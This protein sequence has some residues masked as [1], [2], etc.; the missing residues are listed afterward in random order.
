MSGLD[1]GL[2]VLAVAGAFLGMKIGAVCALFNVAAGLAG[3]WAAG[4]FHVVLA[5]YVQAPALAYGLLFLAVAGVLVA[6]GVVVSQLLAAY[7][8]GLIDKFLGAVLGIALT[9]VFS[10]GALMPLAAE[11]RSS[12]QKLM[13]RSAFA[14]YLLRSAQKYGRLA[15]RDM[16]TRVDALIGSDDLR[17]VRRLLEASR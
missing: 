11:G 3:S 10:A 5:A 2:L 12:V 17:R 7:F 8:L 14:P 6:A 9:L 15:S 13:R 16:W 4:R 1:L